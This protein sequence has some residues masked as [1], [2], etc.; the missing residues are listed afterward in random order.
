MRSNEPENDSDPV[1]DLLADAGIPRDPAGWDVDRLGPRRYWP[2]PEET[3]AKMA[4]NGLV[5][6]DHE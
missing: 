3:R 1:D 5:D 6:P 4:A 2:T